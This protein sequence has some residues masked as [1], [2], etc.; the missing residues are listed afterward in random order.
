MHYYQKNVK[1]KLCSRLTE[2]TYGRGICQRCA[3][4]II[5]D[6]EYEHSGS[7]SKFTSEETIQEWESIFKTRLRISR[8][9]AT[10]RKKRPPSLDLAVF[11]RDGY[12]CVECNSRD[13]LT[14]DHI[15]PVVQGG[16]DELE[17]LQTLCKR[18]NSRKGAK[19]MEEWK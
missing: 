6:F 13:N 4:V 3:N 2:R 15:K 11:R 18:C 14:V 5:L 7:V 9:T 10:K 12:A 8:S 1:C 17:N 19:T 16:G